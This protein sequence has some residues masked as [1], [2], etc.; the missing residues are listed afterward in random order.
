MYVTYFQFHTYAG[1]SDENF[2][3]KWMQAESRAENL[4]RQLQNALKRER[5]KKL[6]VSS[7]VEE[8]KEM[9]LLTEELQAKLAAFE[10]K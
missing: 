2:K 5:R 3:Q 7:L 9:S 1:Q 6:T 10:S 8:L 4:E